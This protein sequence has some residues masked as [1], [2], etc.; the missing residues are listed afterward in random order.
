VIE[1]HADELVAFANVRV[2]RSTA[3]ALFCGIGGKRVWLP[4]RHISGRLLCRG[5][6]GSLLI[7]RWLARDRC[8]LDASGS[9]T[10]ASVG[11]GRDGT[12]RFAAAGAERRGPSLPTKGSACRARANPRCAPSAPLRKSVHGGRACASFDEKIRRETWGQVGYTRDEKLFPTCDACHESG[13][14]PWASYG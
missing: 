11:V 12:A 3:P 4:R 10:A 14:R 8:L 2:I 9:P 5:D 13:W 1:D 7:R 6:H